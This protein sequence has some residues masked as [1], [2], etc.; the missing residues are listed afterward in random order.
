VDN[1][2][3]PLSNRA[4][5]EFSPICDEMIDLMTQAKCII[6][7]GEF[8]QTDIVLKKGDELK[9]KISVIRKAQNEQ[10]AK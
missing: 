3:K 5:A 2:F 1:N 4:R 10:N 8:E 6:E 9:K 7:T